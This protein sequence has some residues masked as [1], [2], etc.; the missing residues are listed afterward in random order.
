M[1][2]LLEIENFK[3]T[4]H[5]ERGPVPAVKG[6][7]LSISRGETVALVGESGCGKTALCRAI[8]GLHKNHAK[9]EGGYIQLQ[10]KDLTSLKDKDMEAIRGKEIAMVFQDP[11]TSLNPVHSIGHQ[12]AEAVRLHEKVPRQEAWNR[13]VTLLE[14]MEIP[15]AALRAKQYPHQFSGG[16]RQRA[17]LAIALAC[18]PQLLIADEP[19]TSL[20]VTTQGKLMEL[21]KRLSKEKD[22]AILFVTHDLGLARDLADRVAVMK[23]GLLVEVGDTQTI[24]EHPQHPYTQKLLGYAA[25]G[26]GTSHYHGHL[27]DQEKAQEAKGNPLVRV[28]HLTKS[29]ALGK[30]MRKKVLQDIN[31]DI[32]TG[33]IL[34]I[35]G[36]SGCGKST[37]ARCLMGIEKPDSGKIQYLGK[38]SQQM[39]F[40]DSASA[41]NP[42]MTL[43]QIIQEPL[44]L[45]RKGSLWQLGRLFA[46]RKSWEKVQE[47]VNLVGLEPDL[48]TRHPYE[49]S[50]GQR[51]RAAIARALITEPEFVIADEPISSL[52]IPVQAQIIHL[53]KD[54]HDQR[55]LTMMII[56][57]DLPMVEHVSDRIITMNEQRKR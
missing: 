37:L 24:F 13:A 4:F 20:D 10:G 5:G 27:R 39:I 28:E 14:Q 3:L 18:G 49:V 43:A 26:K 45:Q 2:K 44:L 30:H 46:E 29:F 36:D 35:V 23:E 6:V 31:L 1:E 32:Q 48:L 22:L 11:M 25:Y 8:L 33:E 53:L 12:V 54:I 47:M 19:T 9:I 52:D 15:Q 7:S 41:F 38:G 51:Q 56:A 21:L 40:Q 34:G 17:A 57:H 50:G 16:M 55:N 42:R